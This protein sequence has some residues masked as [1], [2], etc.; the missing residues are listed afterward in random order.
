MGAEMSAAAAAVLAVG[1]VSLLLTGVRAAVRPAGPPLAAA[2]S[3]LLGA[4]A[5]GALDGAG[6]GVAV[7]AG[8][9]LAA[10]TVVVQSRRRPAPAAA[11][12]APPIDV[13]LGDTIVREIMVPR[14]DMVTIPADAPVDELVALVGAEG[15]SRIPVTG[16]GADD[17]VG[18]ALAKD[19]LVPRPRPAR[20]AA[21]LVRPVRFVPETMHLADLLAA[22]RASGSH[23]AIVVDE[24]GGTAGL[25]TIEDV[26]EELVGDIVDEFDGDEGELVRPHPGGGWR[27]DG[28]LP[29]WDLG[30]LVG[31]PLPA[32]EWDS[33]GGLVLGLAGRV[34]AVGSVLVAAGVEL[35]VAAVRGRRVTEVVVR[36]APV[37]VGEELP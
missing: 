27:V 28:R 22:M 24:Y 14:P 21:D 13:L 34:P 20:R 30:E 6:A 18:I 19:L 23:L 32:E 12:A 8:A 4:A 29:V 1:G 36:P 11:P 3:V 10:A 9:G 26:L 31:V 25:V 17:I 35:T 33:V 37:P 16:A 2:G 5:G 7:A 15:F